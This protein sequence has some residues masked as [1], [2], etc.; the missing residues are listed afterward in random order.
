MTTAHSNEDNRNPPRGTVNYTENL[1]QVHD[2]QTLVAYAIGGL[3][4]IA[5]AA[6]MV[7][8]RGEV[9]TTNVAL[10]LVLIVVGTAAFGGRGPAALSAIVTAISYEF[11]FTKPFESLRISSADDLETTLILLAIGMAVGQ[12]AVH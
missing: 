10:V 4:P 11:F 12:L 9:N 3:L 6:V 5:V 1:A 7:G 2:R 8:V